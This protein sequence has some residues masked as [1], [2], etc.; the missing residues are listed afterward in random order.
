MNREKTQ[1]SK[2]EPE[3]N[4][5]NSEWTGKKSKIVQED[6]SFIQND[7]RWR[8]TKTKKIIRFFDL[9]KKCNY[10]WFLKWNFF[11]F[12]PKKTNFAVGFEEKLHK[13][14]IFFKV[15]KS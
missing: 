9:T 4:T 13:N 3:K 10:F 8:M 5:I 6:E 12:R 14:L 7:W 1:S 11:Y 2:D 15:K